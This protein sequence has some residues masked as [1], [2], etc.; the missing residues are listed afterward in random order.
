MEEEID[1]EIGI[2]KQTESQKSVATSIVYSFDFTDSSSDKH[3]SSGMDTYVLEYDTEASDSPR[4]KCLALTREQPSLNVNRDMHC[5]LSKKNS[6]S[7]TNFNRCSFIA[8]EIYTQT[9]KTII[10]LAESEGVRIKPIVENNSLETQ[11]SFISITE[12]KTYEYRIAVSA[13]KNPVSISETVFDYRALGSSSMNQL[14]TNSLEDCSSKMRTEPDYDKSDGTMSPSTSEK[15]INII[16]DESKE[17]ILCEEEN[18]YESSS[19]FEQS[20]DTT[21]VEED[22]LTEPVR[23]RPNKDN[24][25]DE[26]CDT[27]KS[28]DRDV[29]ELYTKLCQSVDFHTHRSFDQDKRRF[30]QLTPLTEESVARKDSLVDITPSIVESPDDEDKDVLFTNKAGIKVKLFPEEREVEALKLPPIQTNQPC[31]PNLNHL[32]TINSNKQQLRAGT[33]PCVFEDRRDENKIL[34]R[35]EISAK[36]LASGEGTLISGRSD[37]DRGPYGTILLP[38]IHLEGNSTATV[39]KSEQYTDSPK[40][41]SLISDPQIPINI[42]DKIQELKMSHKSRSSSHSKYSMHTYESRSCSPNTDYGEPQ[43]RVTET[44]ERGCELICVELL[45]KL[46]SA[47]WFDVTDTLDDVPRVLEKFWGVITEQRIADLLRQ[48]TSHVESPRTQVAR[49]ACGTLA[50]ILKNTNYTKKPD[51]YEAITILLIKTGSFSRPVRRAANVALDDIVCGVDLCHIVTALCIHGANH[52][53]ALVRCAAARLL[54]VCCALGGGGRELLRAR[55]PTAAAARR[56]AL[57]SLASLL[58]DKS[59]DARKYAERLYSM[60]R[61]L[62]NFEAYYLTDVEVELASRQ[63]KKYDQL[64]LC[65]PP[66]TR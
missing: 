8:Q 18:E 27:P 65:G 21:D 62:A 34:D 42:K 28:V 11:T 49:A 53:S 29:A 66:E 9:S 36:E 22:S 14:L 45:K 19:D 13:G 32:F 20:A 12:N 56:H 4:D 30:G 1:E 25:N 17:N 24:N 57:R 58:D 50:A 6:E 46:R 35:W 40:P 38:P 15:I 5:E 51:F 63:M 7:S 10:E 26:D 39:T 33:L 54:V 37:I 3:N 47:S 16:D 43:P 59:T 61:P 41:E 52:K 2:V 31:G 48:V 44:A 23:Q 64:L 55:P 60:L